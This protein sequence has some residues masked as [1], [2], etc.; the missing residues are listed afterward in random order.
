LRDDNER[1]N[2]VMWTNESITWWQQ[3]GYHVMTTKTQTRDDNKR[4]NH[5]MAGSSGSR[6]FHIFNYRSFEAF[7]RLHHWMQHLYWLSLVLWH[8]QPTSDLC[9]HKKESNTYDVQSGYRCTSADVNI[10]PILGVAE[11][12]TV[13]VPR[14]SQLSLIYCTW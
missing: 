13:Q 10:E 6:H 8:S 2:H 7:D 11:I 9:S 12:K 3:K 5:V 14:C 1:V 4:V